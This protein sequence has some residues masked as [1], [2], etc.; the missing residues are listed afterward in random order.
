MTG[1]TVASAL[2]LLAFRL[3]G[4]NLLSHLW[5]ICSQGSV[6]VS[7]QVWRVSFGALCLF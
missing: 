4:F 2:G 3:L 1:F 6:V 7:S 5:I